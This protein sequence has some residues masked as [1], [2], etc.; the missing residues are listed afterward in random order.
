MSGVRNSA[1]GNVLNPN[2]AP[3]SIPLVETDD[4]QVHFPLRRGWRRPNRFVHAVDDISIAVQAGSTYAIVGESGSGKTTLARTILGLYRPTAGC[5]RYRG[6]DISGLRGEQLL[7]YRQNVQSVFQNPWSSLNPRWKVGSIIADPLAAQKIGSRPA[8]AARV[9]ELLDLVG[10]P[11]AF[12]SHYPHELSGGQRQRVAIARALAPEPELLIL[13]EPVSSLDVSIAAQIMNLLLRLQDELSLTYLL[14]AHDLGVV[15]Y[16][17]HW[18]GVMYLGQIVEEGGVEQL[19]RAALDGKSHP[20]TSALFAAAP[21]AETL[22]RSHNERAAGEIPSPVFPPSG[23]RFHTRCPFAA[24]PCRL[25]PPEHRALEVGTRAACHIFDPAMPEVSRGPSAIREKPLGPTRREAGVRGEPLLEVVDLVTTISTPEGRLPAVDGATFSIGEGET[26]GLVGESGSGKSMTA[27]SI[28]RVLPRAANIDGGE[29]RFL[30]VDLLKLPEEQMRRQIRGKRIAM[31]LQDPLTSLNPVFTIGTQLNEAIKLNSDRSREMRIP[32]GIELLENVH[33]PD[34]KERLRSYPHQLSGGMRQ[35]V[36]GAMALAGSPSLLI[37][38]EPT[39][40]LDA[41]VQ[42]QFLDLLT[43]L[44]GATGMSILF[45]THDLSL[46]AEFCERVVVMYAGRVVETGSA[47]TVHTDPAHPYTRGLIASIPVISAEPRSRLQAIPGQP[48]SILELAKGCRFAPRCESAMDV[49]W[50]QSPALFHAG[51]AHHA[52]CW[53][54]DE[55]HS[56]TREQEDRIPTQE[57]DSGNN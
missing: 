8:R 47:E 20:Y 55:E 5:V 53:L 11:A 2:E 56:P 25:V 42:G 9:A 19:F 31:I 6:E 27:Q 7:R 13:D 57:N 30:G 18:I 48:P 4:L 44:Q 17:A 41:T 36:V 10:L 52:A 15:A 14:I 29:V 49:C 1:N 45:I 28:M 32:F 39:T 40:S 51:D 50:Q 34:A 26:V 43:E 24:E 12:A 22:A 3:H 35:R 23:C 33:I 38:D 16:M 21:G 54:L 37:A 46:I